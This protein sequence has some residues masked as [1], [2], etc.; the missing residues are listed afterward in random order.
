MTWRVLS[1]IW[2]GKPAISGAKK[3]KATTVSVVLTNTF[4]ANA[5]QIKFEDEDNCHTIQ[6][7]KNVVAK[8]SCKT[9][10]NVILINARISSFQILISNTHPMRIFPI[11]LPWKVPQSSRNSIQTQACVHNCAKQVIA[12]MSFAKKVYRAVFE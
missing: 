9:N 10:Q 2:E 6:N 4:S 1:L 8:P 7:I 3:K 11:I 12:T 5:F